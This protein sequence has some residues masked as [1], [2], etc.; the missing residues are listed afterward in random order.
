MRL[1]DMV[2]T[3]TLIL[4]VPGTQNT[5]E[6]DVETI[7]AGVRSGEIALDNWA[8]SPGR[9]EWMPLAQLP[10]Y[11]EAALAPAVPA[12]PA[13]PVVQAVKV[14]AVKATPAQTVVPAQ[15]STAQKASVP[16]GNRKMAGTYYSK[17]IQEHHEFPIF[18]ILF[19]VMGLIIAALVVVN[20][21][22]VDQ[23]FRA[24]L[25][26]T[27]F[28]GVQ[29]HA[30]LGAFVQPNALLVHIIPNSQLNED[31]FADFLTALTQSAPRSAFAGRTFS[32]VG[33]TSMWLSQYVITSDDWDGFAD[34]SGYTPEEKKQY[35]LL[36]L[37]KPDGT[38]LFVM[39]KN[40]T[41]EESRA[42]E[43][44]AWHELVANF[45]SHVSS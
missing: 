33:L 2:A 1:Y 40:E 3:R 15:V 45:Q 42:R 12:V 14:K 20:Y 25:A 36:H 13:M 30:H 38:P 44:K 16:A 43:E 22:M 24:K 34:M 23:P 35:V 31:N 26:K 29:A 19:F 8:W 9:N 4:S 37:E 18:K 41:T 5:R 27:S 11:A 17:P 28:S 39:L 21:S 32:T 7:R 10:E 6:L